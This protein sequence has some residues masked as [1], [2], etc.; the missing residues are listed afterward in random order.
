MKFFKNLAIGSIMIKIQK[1]ISIISV[2]LFVIFSGCSH[3]SDQGAPQFERSVQVIV[4]PVKEESI[5]QKVS[6]IGNLLANE[7]VEIKS[8]IDGVVED[9][10][11]EEGEI[12]YKEKELFKIN[13]KKL[14]AQLAQYQAK[15]K[16]S[17]ASA[18]RYQSL[19]ESGAVSPQEYDQSVASLEV[20]KANLELAKEDFSDGI[21]S[22][23]FKGVMGS[24]TV[25]VGQFVSKGT[26]LSY[27]MDPNPMKV[28]FSISE[29]YLADIQIDQEIEVKIAAYP[30]Q[31]FKGLVYFIDP[32]INE[33]TRTVSIKA[34]VANPQ[35]IL[36][37]GMFANVNLITQKIQHALMIPDKAL[38]YQGDKVFVF[39]VN[40]DERAEQRLVEVGLLIESKAQILSGLTASDIVIS[41]GHQKVHPGVKVSIHQ[42]ES[43]IL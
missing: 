7:F 6:L 17:E 1:F 32:K 26:L 41:E 31:I 43:P 19:I 16:L 9:I 5:D 34:K 28:E 3:K 30:E 37:Q 38:I 21:I 14:N 10:L 2:S 20:D 12:V 33:N 25:S 39:I 29:K 4:D 27:L 36:K 8:E 24:R 11:F 13:Q 40:Q 22:A 15:L 42:N 23:P 18:K 35:G